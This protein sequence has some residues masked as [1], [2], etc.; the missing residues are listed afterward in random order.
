MNYL[1]VE[2]IEK[3]FA[4]KTL[5]SDISFGIERGQKTA[6]VGVN[7]AG[8]STLFN[9]LMG[10]ESADKGRFSFTKDIKV[11]MLPQSPV[12]E[13]HASILDYVLSGDDEVSKTVR[14]YEEALLTND[15]E[16][17]ERGL[18]QMEALNAWDFEAKAKE[19][20][21]KLGIHDLNAE[22]DKLS[23]GQQKRVA[24]AKLLIEAPDF[25]LLD[26][27]TNH[28]DL[29][30]IEWL[31]QYLSQ[32][33]M[34]LLLVTHDRYFLESVTNDIL[35]LDGGNV[36][37]YKGSY[38][39]F[40]EKKVERQLNEA[41]VA[42]KAQNLM[43][44][45]LEWMRR[46]PKARGTK[47]K[48][49]V[50]AFG[51]IEQAAKRTVDNNDININLSGRRMGK[52]ILEIDHVSKSYGE[53]NLIEDFS[54]TFK[55]GDRIGIIG[56]NGSGK[57]TFLKLITQQ[58]APDNGSIIQGE[59]ISF[60][61]YSQTT[62]NYA[63]TDKVIDVVKAIAEVIELKGG[64]VITA[65]Q[66]LNEFNFSPKKQY[67]F[68]EKLSGGEKRRLQLLRVLMGN[69]NFL[70]LDEPTNDLD[71]ITLNTL[72]DYLDS[73]G[74]CLVIVSHDRYFID[75]LA[76]HLFVFKGEGEIQDFAGNFT[77]FRAIKTVKQVTKIAKS[78]PA[79]IEEQKEE[80][81][82]LSY[83]E[84][85]EFDSLESQI[86]ELENEKALVEKQLN[87]VGEDYDKLVELGKKLES[88]KTGIL[89]KENRWLELSEQ[90]G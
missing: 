13:E 16:K 30:V 76:D 31:E 51:D 24:L 89:T 57:T 35:E 29:E 6:I 23:G 53:L 81:K 52:K 46:Q 40:L 84:Q 26:E 61:Y 79:A 2:K 73:F 37:R 77:D 34:S 1:S 64:N 9:I 14:L 21:G 11:R 75:R 48:Y 65:S 69:P 19:I 33:K 10:K 5:F 7:G 58:L 20:L 39:Y 50:E 27:P 4:D 60:G 49:R 63:P 44:K 71:L 3:R 70:I 90:A 18:E 36:Y 22:A 8:K 15:A 59:T 32:Q 86:A 62:P 72:E 25:L 38:S 47:A 74:G 88:I 12:I 55:R 54:Y 41:K 80:R 42:E 56:H 66:L 68:V 45:E 83:N 67:D 43:R 17:L 82:K 85:R 78:K 28:L 87:L